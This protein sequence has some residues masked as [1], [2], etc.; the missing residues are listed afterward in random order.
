MN[1]KHTP[2]RVC[3]CGETDCHK[4]GRSGHY[5]PTPGH[6]PS[7]SFDVSPYEAD[8]IWKIAKR[9]AEMFGK[10]CKTAH[11]TY[12]VLDAEMDLSACVAN[13][14]PL[15]LAD[16][17][18][19]DDMNFAH[20]IFGIRANLNRDTG[21]LDNCFSPRYSVPAK[22]RAAITKATGQEDR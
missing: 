7:P 3:K 13:G 2:G 14:C 20:D 18:K 8:L 4:D 6:T 12:P 9:A 17:L 1:T 15:R 10:V 11:I 5:V 16:L 19:A 21:K 22:A